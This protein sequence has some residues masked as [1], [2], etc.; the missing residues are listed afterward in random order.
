ML[1]F[2]L[3]PELSSTHPIFVFEFAI[4]QGAF[5]LKACE[6][7][8]ATSSTIAAPQIRVQ[9]TS[10]R[11]WARYKRKFVG[12]TVRVRVMTLVWNE[13]DERHAGWPSSI[14]V[15][16]RRRIVDVAFLL[17]RF[18]TD[19]FLRAGLLLHPRP[20]LQM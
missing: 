7:E 16:T 18:C 11:R 5:E 3:A 15:L 10:E 6:R 17:L 4:G 20:I 13:R 12:V 8:H 1:L 9:R 2:F 19:C 14:N